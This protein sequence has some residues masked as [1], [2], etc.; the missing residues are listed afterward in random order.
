MAD[1]NKKIR[2]LIKK[3]KY[4]LRC[5]DPFRSLRWGNDRWKIHGQYDDFEGILLYCIVREF[6]PSRVLEIGCGC[7]YSTLHIL[8][9]LKKNQKG[10][11][12]SYDID[13]SVVPTAR[14]IIKSM[15]LDTYSNI[16][17]KDITKENLGSIGKYDLFFIDMNGHTYNDGDFWTKNLIPLL[18]KN[19]VLV[20]DILNL[21]DGPESF[22]E[23]IPVKEFIL[24]NKW[25][26]V[27]I[28]RTFNSLKDKNKLKK[29]QK[30]FNPSTHGWKKETNPTLWMWKDM[31]W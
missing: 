19:N 18:S 17:S 20:H 3:Y 27:L 22:E 30:Y 7:G 13:D 1:M 5:L 10:I 15:N 21:G 6:A 2:S 23:W 16:I 12:T 26:Y 4:E 14:E 28:H 8:S 11:C 31:T 29:M 24:R 9:A 25:N